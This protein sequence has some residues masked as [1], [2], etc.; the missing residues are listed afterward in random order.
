MPKKRTMDEVNNYSPITLILI[1]AKVLEKITSNQMLT[2][3]N[4]HNILSFSLFVFNVNQQ[5]MQ[6]SQLQCN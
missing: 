4:K 6:Q 2:F 5:K 1:P 3:F